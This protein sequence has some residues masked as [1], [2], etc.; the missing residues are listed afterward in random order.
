M[1]IRTE[2][3][4]LRLTRPGR[5]IPWEG[6]ALRGLLGGHFKER[7][8]HHSPEDRRQLWVHCGGC[9]HLA[10]C[11]YGQTFE[12]D[13]PPGVK[14]FRGQEEAARPLILAPHFPLPTDAVVGLEVPLRVIG[15]GLA[16]PHL[17]TV[18]QMLAEAGAQGGLG[19]DQVGFQVR[20]DER[21]PATEWELRPGELPAHPEALPGRLPRVGVGLTG[22]LLL[23]QRDESDRRQVVVRPRFAELFRACLRTVGRMF[24][25]T[26][27]PLTADFGALAAAAEKV[28]RLDDCYEPFRQASWSSRRRQHRTV[29]G[30]VGGGLYGAVPLGL[31]PWLLWGGRLHVGSH[32]LA[33]AGGWRLVLD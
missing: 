18:R 21:Q 15:V 14:V 1:R 23:K 22:P 8:C 7:V 3:L 16:A 32:R 26:G 33:G 11:A 31:L 4:L 13:P 25:Q 24:A 27:E 20:S 6:L 2:H 19:P 17:A 5:L 29:L 9:P 12:P 28:E 30:V 10:T